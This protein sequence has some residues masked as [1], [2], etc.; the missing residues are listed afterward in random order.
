MDFQRHC[1]N[2]PRTFHFPYCVCVCLFDV[3]TLPCLVSTVLTAWMRRGAL[4]SVYSTKTSSS[5]RAVLTTNRNCKHVHTHTHTKK[6]T[7][8]ISVQQHTL[9]L[10]F[11]FTLHKITFCCS[12]HLI[13]H[14]LDTFYIN[15]VFKGY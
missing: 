5:F 10:T 11:A 8:F 15:C 14:C 9:I 7:I 12:P 3:F 13:L 6:E 2:F 4:V 1:D